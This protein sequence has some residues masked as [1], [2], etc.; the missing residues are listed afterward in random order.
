MYYSISFIIYFIFLEKEKKE[1][2]LA[3]ESE[4]I[5]ILFTQFEALT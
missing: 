3:D 4:Q 5:D 1:L 2:D